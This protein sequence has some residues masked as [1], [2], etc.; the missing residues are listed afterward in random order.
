MYTCTKIVA[1]CSERRTGGFNFS[2]LLTVGSMMK[3][4]VVVSSHIGKKPVPVE[5][6]GMYSEIRLQHMLP[7]CSKNSCF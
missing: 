3:G 6:V 5:D 1:H 2:I 7:E 4:S